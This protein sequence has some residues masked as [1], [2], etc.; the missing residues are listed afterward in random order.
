MTEAARGAVLSILGKVEFTDEKVAIRHSDGVF[1]LYAFNGIRV[2][3]STHPRP[4][5]KYA[6]A[7]GAIEVRWD[8]DL[9]LAAE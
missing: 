6:E 9:R 1:T 3:E 5:A 4:L 2:A 7:N 8:F